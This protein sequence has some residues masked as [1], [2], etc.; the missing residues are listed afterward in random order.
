MPSGWEAITRFWVFT[1][2]FVSIEGGHHSWVVDPIEL[3][4]ISVCHLQN[5]IYIFVVLILPLQRVDSYK[6]FQNSA[7][8]SV[9]QIEANYENNESHGTNFLAQVDRVATELD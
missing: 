6:E 1:D 7:H 5:G 9:G 2:R 3:S 8:E 4:V